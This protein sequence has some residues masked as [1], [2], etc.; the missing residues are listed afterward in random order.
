[1]GKKGRKETGSQGGR[2]GKKLAGRERGGKMMEREEARGKNVK[3]EEGER[4]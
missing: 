2:E 4:L 3:T 1:M